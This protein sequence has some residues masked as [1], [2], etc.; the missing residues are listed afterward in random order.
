[1]RQAGSVNR[2]HARLFCHM[3][4]SKEGQTRY[5]LP[6]SPAAIVSRTSCTDK[7]VLA[8]FDRSKADYYQAAFYSRR[9]SGLSLMAPQDSRVN[10]VPYS[11]LLSSPIITRSQ[12]ALI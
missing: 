2:Q 6:T 3:H 8:P 7:A 5:R 10:R 9:P 11:K 4:W 12:I 1:M